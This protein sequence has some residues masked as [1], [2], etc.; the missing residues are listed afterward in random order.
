MRKTLSLSGWILLLL[1]VVGLVGAAVYLHAIGQPSEVV[2]RW[3]EN[4]L[5]FMFGAFPAMVG[6]FYR[7]GG[8]Q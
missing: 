7:P 4:A 3:A 6:E 5:V 1:L 2:D 8:Q